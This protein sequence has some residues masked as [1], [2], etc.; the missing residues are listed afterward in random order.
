MEVLMGWF[1]SQRSPEQIKADIAAFEKEHARR[2]AR[3]KLQ[4]WWED[5]A[6]FW[7]IIVGIYAF[8]ASIVSLVVI[9][10]MSLF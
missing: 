8:L 10:L 2:E 9:G 7:A 1:F 4:A 5:R 3:S 6:R